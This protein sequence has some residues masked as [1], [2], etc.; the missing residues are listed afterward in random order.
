VTCGSPR[1]QAAREYSLIRP[2]RTGF[3]D[4]LAIEVGKAAA[5]VFAVGDALGD[6]LVRP[7]RVVVHQAFGQYCAQIRL[8]EN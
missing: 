3:V 1:C 7:G 5:V 8:T 6:A 4:P 2:P